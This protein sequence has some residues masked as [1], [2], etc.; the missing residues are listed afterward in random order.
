MNPYTTD[1][2]LA[3][4]AVHA[5][6][7]KAGQTGTVRVKILRPAVNFQAGQRN[8]VASFFYGGPYP[9]FEIVVKKP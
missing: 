4:A 9:A 1:S 5:G 3:H 8:G 2:T 6:V 7:L